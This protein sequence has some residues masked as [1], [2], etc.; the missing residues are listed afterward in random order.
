MSD[1]AGLAPVGYAGRAPV[2]RAGRGPT[3]PALPM[4]PADFEEHDEE[5]GDE[6]D[7]EAT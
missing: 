2:G 5:P 6:P 4:P 3:R 7:G 1:R